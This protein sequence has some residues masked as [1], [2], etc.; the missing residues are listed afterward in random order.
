MHRREFHQR[1]AAAAVGSMTF[2][3][4]HPLLAGEAAAAELPLV[5]THQH[6]WD[7]S[8][9]QLRWLQNANQ[10][11]RRSYVITDYLQATRGLN[12]TKA[13]YMEVDVAPTDQVAEVEAVTQ[14]CRRRDNP[15]VA[16][17]IGGRPA[18]EEFSQYARN[19]ATNPYVRGVRQVLH[20]GTPRG[21][22][23]Q[24][25]FVRAMQLLGELNLSF[26]ICLRAG[27]LADAVKLVDQCPDT[28]FII[29]H[30]GNADPKAFVPAAQRKEKPSHEPDQWR[31]AMEALGQ[32]EHVVC[33]ISGIVA[34]VPQTGWDADMLAPIVNHC[35]DS[36]GPN[37]VV[38]GSDWP[39]C[40]I[41][42]ELADWVK[43]L[44]QIVS[45]RPV[46]EQRR[47]FSQN[48]ERL[49]RLKT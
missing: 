14:L 3:W 31:R 10:V 22:C 39:V 21:Y 4:T 46:D 16:A 49:Y 36:F 11:L 24:G 29:D 38:F 1:L 33:K 19:M 32:R 9:Q 12:I 8:R 47:L 37:R 2:H 6:L 25:A 18:S 15:T 23:L 41:G 20:G 34:R 45:Q 28:L 40:R 43:A 30:C 17:V 44:R 48:A 7:L 27:E 5:D 35:L 42:A 13:V 26:D